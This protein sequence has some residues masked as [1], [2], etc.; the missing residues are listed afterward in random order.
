MS[1][2]RWVLTIRDSD[3][4]LGRLLINW[5]MDW[6]YVWLV[7]TSNCWPQ[8]PVLRCCCWPLLTVV[9]WW[10]VVNLICWSADPRDPL[11]G[12]PSHWSP[13]SLVPFSLV[14]QLIGPPIHYWSSLVPHLIGPP[15]HWSPISLVPLFISHPIIGKSQWSPIS[16]VPH[17]IGS[18]SHWSPNSSVP[19]SLVP[20]LAPMHH[21]F[22]WSPISLVPPTHW[23]P[24]SM[25]PH[26]IGPFSPAGSP[27]HCLNSLVPRP[28]MLPFLP[29]ISL[30]PQ[31]YTFYP[32]LIG[33]PSHWS[34][35]V[36]LFIQF[37]LVPDLI[38]PPMRPWLHSSHWSPISLVPQCDPDYTVLIG[39]LISLVPNVTLVIQ[40]SSVPHLIGPTM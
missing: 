33:P 5:L 13:I 27:P 32:V 31:Y 4:R 7:L 25:V 15:Y 16:L 30:V 37:S 9:D 14:P 24:I 28:P 3:F 18:P 35:N 19:I 10:T 17:L 6:A 8:E 1:P 34:P 36:I 11:T 39:P 23:S 29:C 12:P 40:F 21:P 38:G 2:G 20:Q 22:H 26:L